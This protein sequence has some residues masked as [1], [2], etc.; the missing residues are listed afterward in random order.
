MSFM[1]KKLKIEISSEIIKSHLFHDKLM[2]NFIELPHAIFSLHPAF[3]FPFSA[4]ECFFLL[5]R[6]PTMHWTEQSTTITRLL[7]ANSI[8]IL[9]KIP[10]FIP[11]RFRSAIL[12]S[13]PSIFH[14][15]LQL[16]TA[17]MSWMMKMDILR[18]LWIFPSHS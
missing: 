11:F 17:D 10:S 13:K 2:M 14:S 7:N 16:N 15:I 1:R 18:F 6:L 4:F 9:E 8:S 5:L 12:N 3:I